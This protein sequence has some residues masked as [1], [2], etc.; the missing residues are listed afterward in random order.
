VRQ[1]IAL[2]LRWARADGAGA[3]VVD[4]ES[5]ALLAAAAW[6]VIAF[7]SSFGSAA[8]D[9]H[10]PHDFPP[11]RECCANLHVLAYALVL[12]LFTDCIRLG[13][14]LRSSRPDLSSTI[15]GDGT[16]FGASKKT[17]AFCSTRWSALKLPYAWSCCLLPACC[18]AVLQR[19]DC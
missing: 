11:L 5:F 19:A 18:F 6:I 8:R 12:S 4:R 9:S 7:W 1:R 10:L 3:A 16:S 2:R 15:K 17:G 14:A 13:P